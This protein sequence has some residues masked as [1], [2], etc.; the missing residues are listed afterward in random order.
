[1]SDHPYTRE[2]IERWQQGKINIF[3]AMAQLE[4]E[5]DKA[6]KLADMWEGECLDQAE[7]NGKGSEREAKL[8]TERDQAQKEILDLKKRLNGVLNA[9]NRCAEK[10]AK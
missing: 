5:R 3:D 2:A 10:V 4:D 1:M 6:Q 8:I 9:L 7:A